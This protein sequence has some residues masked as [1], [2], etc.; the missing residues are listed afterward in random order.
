MINLKKLLLL[1]FVTA[2]FICAARVSSQKAE[3]AADNFSGAKFSFKS[4]S[5]STTSPLE[6]NSEAIG[7]VVSFDPVGFV[8]TRADDELPFV[9]LYSDSCNYSDLPPDFLKVMEWELSTELSVLDTE[10]RNNKAFVSPYKKEWENLLSGQAKRTMANAP[11]AAGTEQVGPLLSTSWNQNSPYNYYAPT[12]SGGPGGRAYAGCVACA[13]AQIL[14]YHKYPQKITQDYSYTDYGGECTGTHSASDAGTNDYQWEN[15]PN[16]LNGSST[17]EQL[18]VAQLMYHCGVTVNMNFEADGSGAYSQVVPDAL[19]N[20]FNYKTDSLSYRGPSDSA[21]YEK[22]YNS[23]T[24]NR[25][26]YYSFSNG[27]GGHAVVCD[28]CKDGNNLHMNFGWGGSANAWYNMN[29]INGFNYNHDAI[30]N[31]RPK[32]VELA[33]KKY[34]V[35][36]DNNGDGHIS[37]GEDV[38]IEVQIFNSGGLD[39]NSVTAVLSTASAYVS[40]SSPVSVSYGKIYNDMSKNGSF[41]LEIATNAPDDFQEMRL[42]IYSDDK[43]WTNNFNLNIEHLPVISINPNTISL[44]VINSGSDS[45]FVTICN[46]GIS[47]LIVNL[48]DDLSSGSTNYI[49]ADSNSSNGPPYLWQD[50]SSDGTSVELGDNDKTELIPIGFD[51]PFFGENYSSFMI[52]ANGGIG[53][54]DGTIYKS[55][56]KLPAGAMNAPAQFIAPFW[57]DLDPSGASSIYYYVEANQLIV[58]WENVPRKDTSDKETFQVILRKNGQII[59]QYKKMSGTLNEATIGIQGGPQSDWNPPMHGINVA[60]N[61]S[62]VTN[63]LAVSIRPVMENSWLDYYPKEAIISPDK[64]NSFFFVC[65]SENLTGGF[66]NA[67]VS[68]M[69]NDPMASSAGISID[70]NVYKPGSLV[71]GNFQEIKNGEN[72]PSAAD[73][74]DFGSAEIEIEIITN[75]FSVVNSGTTNLLIENITLISGTNSFEIIESSTVE[76]APGESSDFTLVFAPEDVGLFSGQVQIA[77]S[78]EF[79]NPYVFNIF[80]EGVPEPFY[81]SFI[82]YYLLISNIRTN[83]K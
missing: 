4:R 14:R 75:I 67:K 28:G 26:I 27:S 37:P 9:K 15:M 53:L 46:S 34:S 18:A 8:L 72:V 68:V 52:G 17:A 1:L 70:F 54:T 77:N 45:N 82:I 24:L 74:T 25:P 60:Y 36:S 22:I 61:T 20:Y 40:V 83:N 2:Q 30:F 6:K 51:F 16:S 41:S 7:Y 79:N 81:L 71:K 65:S 78:D 13:M 63:E 57:D 44:E 35:T 29:N 19:R 32:T 50:I 73:N 5:I 3:D 21:W 66:F 11:T 33:Y 31:T 58:S 64:S 48:F 56:A 12:A 55:N 80:G 59:F 47:D 49:W 39:A 42:I 10:Q 43:I 23:L 69:N 38:Q 76:L 62:F